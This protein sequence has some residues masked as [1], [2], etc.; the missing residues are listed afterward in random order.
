MCSTSGL[1]C[2][3]KQVDVDAVVVVAVVD[4]VSVAVVDAAAFLSEDVDA[5]AVISEVVVLVEV[6]FDLVVVD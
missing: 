1:F 3:I 4:D 5:V 6:L 2:L